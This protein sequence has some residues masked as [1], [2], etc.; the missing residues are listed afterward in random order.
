MLRII[1][2]MYNAAPWLARCLDSI[3]SQVTTDWSCHIVDDT[4]EDDSLDV[5][6][7]YAA[8]DSRFMVSSNSRR[9]YQLGSLRHGLSDP[10]FRGL[11]IC[12]SVD[13][14]DYLSDNHVLCRVIES[15]SDDNT[16]LTWGSY[17]WIDGTPGICGPLQEAAQIRQLPWRTSHLRTWRLFLW[18]KI[19][20]EDF[21]GPMR[22]PLR[23][24]G[25]AASMFP[26]IE[27]AGDRHVK[28]LESIN[29][30]Y[31]RSNPLS[32]F[33]LRPEEQ[34][35]N[36]AYLRTR[37]PYCLLSDDALKIFGPLK[38]NDIPLLHG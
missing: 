26:M 38:G 21:L 28:F 37:K 25:D 31:N 1:V 29:Y 36:A 16:W 35:R 5:A 32:N 10:E 18:R 27:M 15:Y 19:Q 13:A 12:V 22:T 17:R 30:V 11:D 24:T 3:R 23:T 9:L 20:L 6:E 4:S 7:Q 33:R 2:P 14:D 8:L 34:L